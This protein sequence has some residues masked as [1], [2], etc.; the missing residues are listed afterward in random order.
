MDLTRYL[1]QL[2]PATSEVTYD[3]LVGYGF[4]RRFVRGKI[5]ADIGWEVGYGPQLLAETAESVVV[6]AGSAEAVDPAST[7]PSAPNAS[8]RKIDFPKLPYPEDYFD[9]AVAFGVIENLEQP[10]AL[11]GEARRVL[12]RDGVLVI[13]TPDRQTNADDRSDRGPGHRSG[14]YVHEFRELLEAHFGHASVYR[15]GAVAGDFIFPVS[16]EVTGTPVESASLSASNPRVGTEPPT[17][18]SLIAVCGNTGALEEQPYLLLDRDRRIFDECQ[19]RTEDVELL[20]DEI[21]RMQQTEVQAFQDSLKLHVTEIAYL[22]A[23]VRRS[24]V[25]IRDI[26]ARYKAR[27]RNL[28]NHIHDMESSTTWRLFEPYRRLR[29]KIDARR[30]PAPEST[31]GSDDHRSS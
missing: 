17:T 3:R 25:Q 15:Q 20:R 8:Y 7:T 19:D 24:Q 31:E 11:V 18:R 28:E 21:R 14:M 27:V 29:A 23:Q 4:A 22:R 9:V 5:V 16:G 12:K 13:S 2:M 10:E 1:E 6:L 30:K 26:E